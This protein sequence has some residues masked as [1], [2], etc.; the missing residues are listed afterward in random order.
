MASDA[1]GSS[2]SSDDGSWGFDLGEEQERNIEFT[3]YESVYDLCRNDRELSENE[4]VEQLERILETDSDVL[5]E[6]N[7]FG[8]TML[9][10]AI[11]YKRSLNFCKL[12]IDHNPD[13]VRTTDNDGS[14]R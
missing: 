2:I 9:R 10:Y 1:S 4:L 6:T 11:A 5:L 14:L 3:P 13:L 12:L 8:D 7:E